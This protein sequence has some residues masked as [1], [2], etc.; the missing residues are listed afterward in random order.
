MDH[1]NNQP[2]SQI[3]TIKKEQFDVLF[4]ISQM[5]T[6]AEYSENLIEEA[7]DLVVKVID[8]ERALFVRYEVEGEVGS[9]HFSIISARNVKQ[10]NISDL[11]KF[12]SGVLQRVIE[13]RAPALYHDVQSDPQISQFESI[14]IHEI[15]SVVGV[16]IFY[17]D[18]IWGVILADSQ[19]NRREF[20]DD[21]LR[22]LEFFSSLVSLSL[23]KILRLENLQNENLLL[24]HQL[25]SV[26]PVPEMIGDSAPM[27]QLAA[28][29]HRVAQSDATVLILGESG[30]GKELAAKAIHQLSPRKDKP[31]LAQFC[32]SIPD[33]LLE[34]E[35][36][37]Y[38]KG[39]FTG[40]TSDKKGLFEVA[41][42]GTFFLDE[43]AEI[44][45]SLQAK[46]LRVIQNQEIIRL[47]DSAVKKVNV[48]LI[49]AT[50]KDLKELVKAGKFREDLF[51]RLNVFPITIPPL[52]ERK[53]DVAL[54]TR[55]FI[56]KL[57]PKKVSITRDALN[58]L[59]QHPWPGNVRQLENTIQRALILCD[60]GKIQ[61][62]HIVLEDE[63]P[64]GKMAL[65]GTLKEIEKHI[66]LKRLEQYDGNRTRCA[67]SLG[68]SVRWIQLK[69][70][71]L[72][73][74]E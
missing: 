37:G 66:L 72:E 73:N 65:N 22:F 2:F 47:G 28:L 1:K 58:K 51:Y 64:S 13:Q 59:E 16:P 20:T 69:L 54:L 45:P 21:N 68:V 36:F 33:S 5:L 52:C 14:Q 35:L 53:S 62:E 43:I 4:K 18:A 63:D 32:G 60:S 15:K 48:R 56:K 44:S 55:H 9:D 38:K 31:Y 27:K 39:A 29:L 6:V 8:A 42:E 71:E 23:D 41:D 30:T 40:A 19:K 3:K 12:S 70:K 57:S 34:S 7:L 11:S 17:E 74:N 24:R 67:K 50:N 49:A 61:S 46:L 10:E 26:Q 25:Q